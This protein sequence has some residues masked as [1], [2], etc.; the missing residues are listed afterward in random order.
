MFNTFID[1]VRFVVEIARPIIKPAVPLVAAGIAAAT[2]SVAIQKMEKPSETASDD[3][4]VTSKRDAILKAVRENKVL[5]TAGLALL[6]GA[7][8]GST[9]RL[10]Q[11]ALSKEGLDRAMY[12]AIAH[13]VNNREPGYIFDGPVYKYGYMKI[14]GD[15]NPIMKLGPAQA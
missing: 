13:S 5:F 2:A 14:F 10:V 9:V 12:R 15:T 3:A 4:P 11:V 6:A 8:T 1:N 7:A